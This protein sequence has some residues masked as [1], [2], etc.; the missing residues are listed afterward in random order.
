MAHTVM[1]VLFIQSTTPVAIMALVIP[2]LF[3]LDRDLANAGWLTSN[4]AAIGLA[5]FVLGIAVGL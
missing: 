5:Y 2:Q 3:D 1:Q 4:L